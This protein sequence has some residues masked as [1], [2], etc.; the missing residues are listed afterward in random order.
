MTEQ[1]SKNQQNEIRSILG[2]FWFFLVITLLVALAFSSGFSGTMKAVLFSKFGVFENL[3]LLFYI[4]PV[5]I[6]GRKA[7]SRLM[8][9][10]SDGWTMV[11]AGIAAFSFFMLCEES[12]TN[13]L[14]WTALILF[15]DVADGAPLTAIGFVA[16][17]R[18]IVITMAFYGLYFLWTAR[19]RAGA[20]V[21]FLKNSV[22]LPFWVLFAVLITMPATIALGMAPQISRLGEWF[23]MNA[24]LA[25]LLGCLTVTGGKAFESGGKDRSGT[26]AVNE[27]ASGKNLSMVLN[28]FK[29]E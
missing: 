22:S 19:K 26:V 15:G 21:D 7:F 27:A 14:D 25:W 29:E 2:G 28:F 4:I 17:A 5:F 16:M 18:M 9:G 11:A 6:A 12:I 3:T 8:S 13:I 10:A 23:E 24:A 1:V 20:A